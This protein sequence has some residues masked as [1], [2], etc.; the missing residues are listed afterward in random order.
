MSIY[1]PLITKR[2]NISDDDSI[3]NNKEEGELIPHY[4]LPSYQNSCTNSY[5]ICKFDDVHLYN[6]VVN[7]DKFE[8]GSIK[9]PPDT[10]ISCWP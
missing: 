9:V 4:L 7:N 2:K 10:V 8:D 6:I 3:N 1:V 5:A